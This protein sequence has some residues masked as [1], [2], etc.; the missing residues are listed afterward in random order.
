MIKIPSFGNLCH[1]FTFCH[2]KNQLEKYTPPYGMARGDPILMEGTPLNKN[3][4][5]KC[6][7]IKHLVNYL[8]QVISTD[9][10]KLDH[11]K[12]DKIVNYKIPTH[13]FRMFIKD[14]RSIVKT[15]T[16]YNH[17]DLNRKP[18]VWETEE[19]LAFEQLTQNESKYGT[20]EKKAFTVID[21]IKH[22]KHYL[23]DKP[24]EIFS[25]RR[26]LQSLQ[27]Q[28]E[29]NGRLGRWA[30]LLA[31]TNYELKYRS[32]RIHQNDDRL[33]RLKIGRIQV[34]STNIQFICKKQLT[35]DLCFRIKNELEKDEREEKFCYPKQDWV[36]EIEYF[37]ILEGTLY[38]NKLFSK[39]SR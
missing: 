38:R 19:Q 24:F 5:K 25:D 16:R 17:K 31:A 18:F 39:N 13:H 33:S 3:Y 26:P 36:K 29:N 34:A 11:E 30:I 22:F 12:M 32:G 15:L 23:L 9:G 8:G 2:S 4:F 1:L 7:F 35:D 21:T 10:I 6:Q 20:T 37:K 28:K 27:N 14:F